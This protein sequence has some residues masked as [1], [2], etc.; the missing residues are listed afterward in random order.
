MTS[1]LCG[2]A[3]ATLLLGAC[4]TAPGPATSWEGLD[5]V[6]QKKFDAVYLKR[7]A[8]F[9]RYTEIMLDPLQVSFDRNW[10]PRPGYTSLQRADTGRIQRALADEFRKVFEQTLTADG[11]FRLVT[12][13][14]P[15]TLHIQPAIVDLYINAPDLAMQTPGRVVTYTVD[16]GRMTLAADFRDGATGALLARVVDEKQGMGKGHLQVTNVVTNTADAR[17]ALQQW[18]NAVRDGLDAVKAMAPANR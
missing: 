1:A 16:P 6:A 7:D 9:A 8:D 12:E 17:Q 10:D 2:L 5:L 13:A 15:A 18:A 4:A 11:R 14:G 3:T